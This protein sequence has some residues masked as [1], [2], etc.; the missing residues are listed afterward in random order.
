MLYWYSV[1]ALYNGDEGARSADDSGYRGLAPPLNV[2]ASDDL[3]DSI[4]ITWS[5]ATGATGYAIHRSVTENGTYTQIGADDVSP[6]EDGPFAPPV[7]YWYKLKAT[8][9]FAESAFSNANQGRAGQWH[10]VVVDSAGD[11]G[12]HTS[13]AAVNGNPAISY[14]DE[15][16]GDLKYVRANDAAGDNWGTPVIVDGAGDVGWYTSLVVINGQPAISYYDITN[17]DLKYV[18]AGDADGIC[19]NIPVFLDSAGIV[20][21]YTSL[22]VVN[23]NPAISYHD[24][25]SNYDLKYVRANDANGTSW[26]TPQIPDSVGSVG[27]YTNLV[28]V[29]GNP[30]ISYF[31]ATT[32][33]LKYV[34]ANNAD[35][36]N[37]GT[38]VTV[39]NAG[40]VGWYNSLAVVNGRPAI[41]Y[42]EMAPVGDLWYVQATDA[43]G[44][45]WGTPLLL[46][47]DGDV[48]YSTSLV[49]VNE[50][51]AIGYADFTNYDLKYVW[52]SDADG[53]SWGTP[54]ILDS[55]GNVGR[56]PSLAV[57]GG[58]PAISYYDKSNRDLK[59]A[60]CY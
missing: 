58:S 60:I 36:N 34:R 18:R 29:N 37:W 41:S 5:S 42:Y 21:Q 49:V 53:S 12:R 10:I 20:G 15:T 4:E 55:A 46:D 25:A 54:E 19:W 8:N 44:T 22:A 9:S 57:V 7:I 11:V 16:N 39:D 6:Y 38:P 2:Q 59:F 30:A 27:R 32:S 52:A 24:E 51:P 40:N 17:S 31:G 50:R 14:Y 28:V 23:G 48:G 33:A 47:S 3:S 35:G 1:S 26:G 56:N 45:S 43:N 13:L